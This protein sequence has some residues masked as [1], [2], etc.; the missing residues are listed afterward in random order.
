[1]SWLV[2]KYLPTSAVVV[3]V[4]ETAKRSDNPGGF[5]ASLPLFRGELSSGVGRSYDYKTD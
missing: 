1:M 5:V 4:S 3:L 2:A